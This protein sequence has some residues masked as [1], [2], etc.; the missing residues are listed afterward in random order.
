MQSTLGENDLVINGVKIRPATNSDDSVSS[1]ISKS[2][3]QAASA[4]ATAN[5]INSHLHQTGVQAEPIGPVSKGLITD[6]SLVPS[7]TNSSIQTLYL[8]GV[9]VDVDFVRD[10]P[11][12]SRREKVVRAI[13]ERFGTHGVTATNNSQGVTLTTDG[14]NLSVWFD[15]DI[16]GLSAA[17]FGLAGSDAVAQVSTI[18]FDTV[19][20]EAEPV[21]PLVEEGVDYIEYSDGGRASET[22]SI[23]E[24]TP[25]DITSGAMSFSNG[26]L[27]RGTGTIAEIVGRIDSV[28]NGIAGAPLQINYGYEFTNGALDG[29][30]TGGPTVYSLDGWTIYNEQVQLDGLSQ[31]AGWPTPLDSNDPIGLGGS[32]PDSDISTVSSWV[33]AVTSLNSDPSSGGGNYLELTTGPY[34][35]TNGTER[36]GVIHGPYMVSD[37]STALSAGDVVTFEWQAKDSGDD[38]DVFGYLLNIDTG[39]TIELLNDSNGNTFGRPE[40]PPWSTVTKVIP[41]SG[42][43]KFI[44]IGGSFDYSGG[45]ALGANLQID[46]I[47]ISGSPPTFTAGQ[48]TSIT[49]QVSYVDTSPPVPDPDAQTFTVSINGVSVTSETVGSAAEAAENLASKIQDKISA[50]EIQNIEVEV[51]G[52]DI[53]VRST[54][55]GTPFDIGGVSISGEGETTM[56]VGTQIPNELDTGIVTGIP[57]ANELSDAARTAYGTVRLIASP[58]SV[59]GDSDTKAPTLIHIEAG[60]NGYKREGDFI[61]L[62]FEEGIFGGR[63]SQEMDPPRVG[64]L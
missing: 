13:N 18:N 29:P 36:Y 53:I 61:G 58:A 27:Y 25:P 15:S 7:T 8:N 31:I 41:T 22:L 51:Q 35:I 16:S 20:T 54:V 1:I 50:G 34:P 62:G 60:L 63:S 28:S 33:G 12:D 21:Y 64:R 37:T 48:I 55:A 23:Q 44:F 30:L 9:A 4:I 42:N 47:N 45:T 40:T 56:S 46:S 17:H 38:Y 57:N 10:E 43:Y 6:T 14:R 5:A 49:S 19:V 11:E 59:G 52:E 32:P 39:A 2:S 26:I 3:S 24:T